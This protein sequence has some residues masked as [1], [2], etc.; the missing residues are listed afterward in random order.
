MPFRIHV[1]RRLPGAVL[2][3]AQVGVN[4]PNHNLSR[5]VRLRVRVRVTQRLSLPFRIH[6]ARRLPGA[7]LLTALRQLRGVLGGG[8]EGGSVD[9]LGG[10]VEGGGEG[11]G[12]DGGGGG[13]GGGEGGGGESGAEGGGEGGG[14]DGGVNGGVEGGGVG[15]EAEGDS[16]GGLDADGAAGG[17]EGGGDEGGGGEGGG[18]KGG[19]GDG[20]GGAGGGD[21]GSEGSGEGGG[22]GRGDEGGVKGR[23]SEESKPPSA[24]KLPQ[25]QE[26]EPLST[27]RIEPQSKAER[28]RGLGLTLST[29]LLEPPSKAGTRQLG[30]GGLT[31]NPNSPSELRPSGGASSQWRASADAPPRN[32]PG[33]SLADDPGLQNPLAV[34]RLGRVREEAV[35]APAFPADEI[36]LS[37]AMRSPGLRQPRSDSTALPSYIATSDAGK[38]IPYKTKGG[39]RINPG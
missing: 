12:A 31:L 23:D 15:G 29:T 37:S 25:H 39:V 19:G 14:G 32:A 3:A 1:A 27:T 35:S 26:S 38:T 34:S 24:A 10:E 21:D 6:V 16:V 33:S 11:G 18:G 36:P 2:L 5:K 17:G 4:P 8:V 7:V 22:E 20:G 13:G 28:V 30:L 9:V